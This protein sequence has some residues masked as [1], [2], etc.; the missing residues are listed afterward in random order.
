MRGR[1]YTR[2]G[3]D[4]TT[5]LVGGERVRKNSMRVEAYGTVD[6]LNSH[7]GLARAAVAD[8]TLSRRLAFV[9]QRLFNC[10][11]NLATPPDAISEH[12]PQVGEEDVDLLETWLDE[13]TE[14]SGDLDHF[15]VE[16]GSDPAARLHV[17]RAVTRRAERAILDLDEIEHVDDTVRKFVN[18]LSDFLFASARY[19]NTLEGVEEQAWD[20]QAEPPE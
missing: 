20:P 5:S 3:D 6:E 18:R 17:A 19:A 8:E 2:K 13:M 10:S 12:T 1:I 9:Q 7:V 11:S 4:G 15:V 14:A 16:G